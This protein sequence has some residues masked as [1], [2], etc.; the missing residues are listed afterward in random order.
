MAKSLAD[1]LL[2][3]GLVDKKKLKQAEHQKRVQTKQVQQGKLPAEQSVQEVVAQQ[4]AAKQARDRELNEQR[5]AEERA[6]ALAA[7]V[8]QMLQHHQQEIKGEESFGFVDPRN[9]KVKKIYV[10]AQAHDHL[11]HGRLVLC[12]DAEQYY[13]VP[14][15]I[16][17]KIAERLSEA[18]V[19][20]GAEQNKVEDQEDPYK[21]YPIPDDLMW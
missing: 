6:R 1:Q 20:T 19:Y 11:S 2:K 18:I 8:K 10:S 15:T 9:R 17:N 21:D 12:A 16:A 5:L 13:A 14:R 3:A 4:R 7:Q